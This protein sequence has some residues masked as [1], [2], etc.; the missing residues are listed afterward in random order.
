MGDGL[1]DLLA[2][3][4]LVGY[5]IWQ[6]DAADDAP[7]PWRSACTRCGEV[8]MMYPAIFHPLGWPTLQCRF[9]GRSGAVLACES[10]SHGAFVDLPPQTRWLYPVDFAPAD[11]CTPNL[12]SA[13]EIWADYYRRQAEDQRARRIRGRWRR[14]RKPRV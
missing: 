12:P 9:R 4:C 11:D 7:W 13:E 6:R 14:R 8:G 5:H 10:D 3:E 1:A 2:D